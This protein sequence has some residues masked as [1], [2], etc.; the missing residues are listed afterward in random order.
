MKLN[1]LSYLLVSDEQHKALPPGSAPGTAETINLL[2]HGAPSST[3]EPFGVVASGVANVLG[4]F[5]SRGL[6]RVE[7]FLKRSR[8]PPS[9]MCAT[10]YL[11]VLTIPPN[12]KYVSD[13]LAENSLFLATPKIVYEPAWF[14]NCAYYNP[15]ISHPG[16]YDN[17]HQKKK[18]SGSTVQAGLSQQ[19][20]AAQRALTL[21]R[22]QVDEVFDSLKGGDQL[23]ETN[24]GECN[25]SLTT[26]YHWA[27]TDKAF[28]APVP[29]GPL[30]NTVLY[31]H[32]RKALSFLREREAETRPPTGLS[33]RE[34]TAPER[35]SLWEAIEDPT[36]SS[37]SS[38]TSS[39]SG[40]RSKKTVGWKN[41]VTEKVSTKKPT[42]CRGAILADDV[43]FFT[44]S[45]HLRR[46]SL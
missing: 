41:K 7:G 5:L 22:T 45:I 14:Q 21:Q 4:D 38:S 23:D 27:L 3:T 19:E 37:A 39:S 36:L 10:L 6:V 12:I 42:D 33:K 29:K 46:M 17:Y 26:F 9:R 1:P 20:L 34:W 32:Q 40:K 25:P 13:N 28:F 18:A 35:H 31:P 16:I 15:H 30:I 44:A 2:P 24:P 11:Y 43:S 8:D